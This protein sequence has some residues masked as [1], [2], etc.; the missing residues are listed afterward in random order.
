MGPELR[1]QT[2][3]PGTGGGWSNH[4]ESLCEEDPVDTITVLGRHS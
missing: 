1:K 4:P 2:A 3:A